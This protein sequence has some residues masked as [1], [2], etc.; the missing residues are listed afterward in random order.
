MRKL[1]QRCAESKKGFSM[2]TVLITI[3]FIGI[4]AM[5]VVSISATN[6]YMKITAIKGKESF[7]TAE[8]VLDE[9]K[10]GLQEDVAVAMSEAYTNVLEQYNE[11]EDEN[12]VDSSNTG[13]ALD[14]QRQNKFKKL[15]IEVLEKRL[16]DTDSAFYKM[17]KIRG[18]VDYI[19]ELK[20]NGS[21]EELLVL[22]KDGTSPRMDVVS[23]ESV[24]LRNLKIVHIDTEGHASIIET[25]IRLETPKVAF[26][27]PTNLPDLMNMI[28]VAKN[29]IDFVGGKAGTDSTI[30]IQGNVY[31]GNHIT[32]SDYLDVQVSNNEYMVSNGLISVNP[33]ASF[34]ASSTTSL[35]AEGITAASSTIT[36]LGKTCVADDLTIERGR[37]IGSQVTLSGEYYGYGSK[38][39]ANQ[40]EFYEKGLKYTDDTQADKSSSISINGK[41][42]TL[43][44]TKLTRMMLAGNSYVNSKIQTGTKNDIFFTGESLNVKGTQIAYLVPES[45]IGDGVSK[46]PLTKAQYE[47]LSKNGTISIK[48]DEP[49]Q[50]WD[51]KTLRELQVDPDHPYSQI[52]YPVSDQE[53]YVYLYL[54]FKTEKDATN[55]FDWYYND[56]ET[57]KHEIQQYL[58]FYLSDDGIKMNEQDSFFRLV[59]K[60]NFIRYSKTDNQNEVA[61]SKEIV[62]SDTIEEQINYYNTWYSLTRKMIPNFD[63]LSEEEKSADHEV[64]ENIID[65]TVLENMTS[66]IRKQIEFQ[67]NDKNNNTIRALVLDNSSEFVITED[68]AKELRLLVCTGDVRIKQGVSFQGII[69]TKGNLSIE[70]GTKVNAKPEEAAKLL[71]TEADGKE[72]AT[73]FKNGDQYVIGNS[74]FG[75]SD[76]DNSSTYDLSDYILYENWTKK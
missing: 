19:E 14:M 8:K 25:D 42:T 17:D 35:W 11:N 53:A 4:M 66:N 24:T 1:K 13:E 27:T 7:Y 2:I 70:D 20:E 5:I 16:A 51:G 44:L 46:N 56:S 6:F 47:E 37:E 57:R 52:I 43:D 73:V 30:Q 63:M 10:A 58:D 62:T 38:E 18:Y 69:M 48:M 74:N 76:S 9:I 21:K 39:A 23:S 26:P 29:G 45:C 67:T 59:T 22:T 15:F 72:L 65:E 61:T 55:F 50:K 40:S 60:G 3:A 28:I 32:V 31:G 41:N 54:N 68:V 49:I 12:Q 75:E 34:T 36:L 71:Q 64:F 33:Y